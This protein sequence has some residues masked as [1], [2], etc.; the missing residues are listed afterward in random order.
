MYTI[1]YMYINTTKITVALLQLFI[2]EAVKSLRKWD[3]AEGLSCT[4]GTETVTFSSSERLVWWSVGEELFDSFWTYQTDTEH[5]L[6]SL[7]E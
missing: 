7:T 4:W 1:L 6:L 2:N 3:S 5:F